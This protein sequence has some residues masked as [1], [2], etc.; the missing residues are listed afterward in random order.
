MSPQVS[1]GSAMPAEGAAAADV[2]EQIILKP[3]GVVRTPFKKQEDAPRQG[4][5]SDAVC[6]LELF[7]E[8]EPGLKDVEKASHLIVL[9]WCHRS[10]RNKM[11]TRTPFRKTIRGIFATRSPSRP[12]PIALCVTELMDVEGTRLK[13]RGLDA[14]DGSPLLDIKPYSP[15]ID[16]VYD[17]WVELPE[18]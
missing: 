16:A 7:P 8:Y 5:L 12:N 2:G 3:I 14:M 17:A 18:K 13:V 1:A 4:W 9:Y 10:D 15:G 6:I 11:Q